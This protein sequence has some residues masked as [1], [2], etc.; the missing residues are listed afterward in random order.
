MNVRSIE[1]NSV[2]CDCWLAMVLVIACDLEQVFLLFLVI[3]LY[4]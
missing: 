2:D 4:I 1:F 3:H